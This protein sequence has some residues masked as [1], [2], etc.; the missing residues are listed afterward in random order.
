[1]AQQI[2]IEVPGTKISE[3]EKTS[4]VSRGDVTPVVQ[5][6]E[7]KQ[8]DIGQIADF[9][10]S[11]LGSAATKD[12]S[13]FATPT[14]V[15]SVAIASQQR[16]DAQNERLDNVEYG[17]IAIGN[18]TDKSFSTYAEMIAYVPTESNVTVRNNDPDPTLRGTYIWTGTE[19][20]AGYDPL[21]A[22]NEYADQLNEDTQT[23]LTEKLNQTTQTIASFLE[24]SVYIAPNPKIIPIIKDSKDAILIGFNTETQKIVAVGLNFEDFVLRIVDLFGFNF[25]ESDAPII[26]FKQD[27]NGNIIF[28]FDKTKGTLVGLFPDQY[29]DE[30]SY[31]ISQILFYGQSLSRGG[32]QHLPGWISTT[33]PLSNLAFTG[34]SIPTNFDSFVPLT[35][36]YSETPCSGC[37]NHAAYLA[38]VEN[39]IAPENGVYLAS[40]AGVGGAH[41]R[42]LIKGTTNYTNMLQHITAGHTLSAAQNKSHALEAILWAQGEANLGLN[43]DLDVYSVMLPQFFNDIKADALAITGGTNPIRIISYQLSTRIGLSEVVCK[44]QFDLAKRRE[45]AISCP[46]Y[47]F[48]YDDFDSV[49]FLPA[50]YKW[51]GA[52][53]GRALKQWVKDKRYPDWLE[54]LSATIVGKT[55]TVHFDVPTAPLVFDTVL[56]A[57]TQDN[58]FAVSDGT[59]LLAIE[60]MTANQTSVT[61]E[62]V[63]VPLDISLLKVRYGLDYLGTGKPIADG[64][65][66][67]LR[68]S[69][70]DTVLVQ[71]VVKPM[72]HICPHF[73]MQ[74]INGAI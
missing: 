8:A 15:S 61:I 66:G 50:S 52:Y 38:S 58:G 16:D 44:T 45:I 5:G 25:F 17:L 33:Q 69:T 12:A 29:A 62:L 10:K 31:Q 22:A 51:M 41:L 13:E 56:L 67:N 40:T 65:S 60:S 36:G 34:G 72:Y 32:N 68:D 14:D 28:G 27:K 53:Y 4:S 37:A 74:V 43:I 1:M 71:G 24:L 73:E 64:K 70:P 20:V 35:E 49:H 55:I 26:P 19:Y 9:V 63:D 23:D 47:L 59:N 48:E 30:V 3:L 11:E 42:Q 54:P 6:E 57:P 39:G 2:V 46:T 7:T 18:G 21:D